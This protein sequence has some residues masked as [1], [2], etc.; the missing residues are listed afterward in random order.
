MSVMIYSHTVWP[1]ATKSLTVTQAETENLFLGGSHDL[2]PKGPG[3][4]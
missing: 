3:L 1:R 2:G 4:N